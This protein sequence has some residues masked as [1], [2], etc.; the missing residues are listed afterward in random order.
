MPRYKIANDVTCLDTLLSMLNFHPEV[1]VS[2][3]NTINLIAT[4][5][6]YFWKAL[7]MKDKSPIDLGEFSW[8]DLFGHANVHKISYCLD[9][10]DSFLT[11]DLSVF[12]PKTDEP[13]L[14]FSWVTR[15]LE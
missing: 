13:M 14:R 1:Q 9:I 2:T 8:E 11:T 3:K 6:R 15:F 5:V 12:D 4:N 7:Y 10:M